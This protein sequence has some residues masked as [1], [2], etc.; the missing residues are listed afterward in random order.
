MVE[1]IEQLG[2]K[3]LISLVAGYI[4]GT[5][6]NAFQYFSWTK[7][8][9][10][11]IKSEVEKMNT[12]VQTVAQNTADTVMRVSQPDN[13]GL[14]TKETNE[15]LKELVK[16]VRELNTNIVRLLTIAERNGFGGR[17]NGG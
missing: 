14:G 15:L 11:T 4:L 7:K 17:H 8:S 3:V 9:L 2:S 10:K 1:F 6:T 16:E 5:V 13:W 12:L